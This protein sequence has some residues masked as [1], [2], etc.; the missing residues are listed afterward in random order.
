PWLAVGL[1]W[2]VQ[3][4][5]ADAR[6]QEQRAHADVL[7]HLGQWAQAGIPAEVR[8][9]YENVLRA[10]KDVDTGSVAVGKAKQWMGQASSDYSIGFL[11]V[12]ELS[13]AVEAYVSIRTS[14]IKAYFDHNVAM[15][16]LSK[17]TG[18]LDGD[19]SMFYLAAAKDDAQGGDAAEAEATVRKALDDALAI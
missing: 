16:A 12:R 14:L 18:T 19:S 1:R 10:R 4:Y 11:D 15:A 6:A 13:D 7:M 17:A 8:L 2:E 3:G 5:M 9:A